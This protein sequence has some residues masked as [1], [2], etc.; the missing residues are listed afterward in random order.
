MGYGRS[1]LRGH[2]WEVKERRNVL[3]GSL[4]DPYDSFEWIKNLHYDRYHMNAWIFFLMAER[5][6][7][8]D[9]NNSPYNKNIQELFRDFFSSKPGA[10]K[11]G[12]QKSYFHPGLHPSWQSG[13]RPELIKKEMEIFSGNIRSEFFFDSRQHFIRLTLPTTFRQLIGAGIQHDY[14][15][16]YGSINGFR[17]SVASRFFWYDLEAD[18]PTNLILYPFCYMDANS[19]YEQKLTAHQAL[20]ELLQYFQVIRSVNGMMITVW[21]N[22][23]LGTHRRFAGW[24]ETYEKFIGHICDKIP[25]LKE[26]TNYEGM[27]KIESPG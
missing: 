12:T 26:Q 15:M 25:S 9:K 20:E 14:S 21:H 24:R 23:F 27:H 8:Y 13:D 19:F 3:R 7:R 18:Q 22:T 11:Q 17:A 5:T 6:G 2:W 4:V 16:G 1:L 10:I